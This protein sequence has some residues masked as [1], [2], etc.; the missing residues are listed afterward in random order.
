[1]PVIG[2]SCS[3]VGSHILNDIITLDC[4]PCLD[5][6]YDVPSSVH[7]SRVT[8]VMVGVC[9]VIHFAQDLMKCKRH[10]HI[11]SI[12]SQSMAS[13]FGRMLCGDYFCA[14]VFL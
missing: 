9:Y 10:K 12:C 13:L 8:V 14:F 3:F 4:C 2:G 11:N 6:Y 7:M 5:V 1:M